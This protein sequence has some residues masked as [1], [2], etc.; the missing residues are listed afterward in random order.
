[1]SRNGT[2]LLKGAQDG[3]NFTRGMVTLSTDGAAGPYSTP[4]ADPVDEPP[5]GY[6]MV[7]TIR[8]H[9]TSDGT[10]LPGDEYQRTFTDAHNLQSV[11]IVRVL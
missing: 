11:G 9:D 1:M 8:Q 5:G 7:R 10:K 3:D 2:K 4:A 6:L